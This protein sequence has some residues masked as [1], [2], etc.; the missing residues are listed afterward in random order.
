MIGGNKMKLFRLWW[1]CFFI[2]MGCLP[3]SSTPELATPTSTF[4]SPTSFPTGTST[5]VPPTP[6]VTLPPTSTP[7]ISGL[8]I[9]E[10]LL[11]KP[12]RASEQL[13]FVF[14]DDNKK[15]VLAA[16]EEY[17]DYRSQVLAYNNEILQKF[18]LHMESYN[19]SQGVR[20]FLFRGENRVLSGVSFVEPVSV[21]A[22][23]TNFITKLSSDDGEYVLTASSF[24]KQGGH[25]VGE[26]HL[27][28][29]SQMLYTDTMSSNARQPERLTFFVYLDDQI[30]YE[31]DLHEATP[32][33]WVFGHWSYG[34]HWAIG[35]QDVTRDAQNNRLV[36][37]WIVLDGDNLNE[38]LGYQQSFEFLVLDERPF[39]F[40]QRDGKIGISFDGLE[41]NKGYDEIPHYNCCSPALL[42]PRYS[43]NMIWFFARRGEEW[44]YVEAYV[45]Y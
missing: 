40:Y 22:S 18:D 29:G 6:A 39:Y 11:A 5:A 44:Y 16:T 4:V 38:T 37:E 14:A 9:N 1:L 3:A 24:E 8:V 23:E 2:L 25:H 7:E 27:Y 10:Y 20:Y 13:V 41:I 19:I 43:M 21:N 45:P 33:G 31:I 26:P 15:E 34:Q 30:A 17:R 32:A 36:S 12:P 28:V 35:L 42:N